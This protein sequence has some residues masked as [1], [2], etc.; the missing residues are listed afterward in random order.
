[1]KR[2]YKRLNYL[3]GVEY[4]VLLKY[5]E[6]MSDDINEYTSAMLVLCRLLT[7]RY[8]TFTEEFKNAPQRA[9]KFILAG[10]NFV[11]NEITNELLKEI[12]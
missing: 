11:T 7:P 2:I 1:M 5:I 9:L 6:Y 8:Q 12:K 4:R 10:L 3:S